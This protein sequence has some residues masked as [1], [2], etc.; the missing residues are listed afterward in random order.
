MG[1]IAVGPLIRLAN[2]YVEVAVAPA[3]G[4]R[5]VALTDR[6]RGVECLAPS[7]SRRTVPARNGGAWAARPRGDWDVCVPSI[8]PAD[9]GRRVRDDYGDL[10][11]A[12]WEVASTDGA[13]I[14]RSAAPDEPCARSRTMT[15][16]GPKLAV[17]YT[18]EA[19]GTNA[20]SYLCAMHPAMPTST[21]LRAPFDTDTE[22][23]VE[24][25]SDDRVPIG[26]TLRWG[27]PATKIPSWYLGG[28]PLATPVAMKLFGPT[29]P[30]SRIPVQQD[31]A[32]L[33]LHVDADVV[34]FVG[35]WL[36]YRGRAH[37]A[38]DF[39][40]AVEPTTAATDNLATAH[41]A[42]QRVQVQAGDSRNWGVAVVLNGEDRT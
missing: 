31:R 19:T 17:S 36:N 7:A 12:K 35:A 25:S 8:A 10:W 37:S 1:A 24:Y 39:H 6:S 18:L 30:A 32:P 40:V 13:L 5:V 42:R 33:E 28:P 11:S 14:I 15:L 29:P 27:R 41:D 16:V 4:G 23:T 21:N 34:A 3:T 2:D 26:R 9:L 22:L 20:G 38:G